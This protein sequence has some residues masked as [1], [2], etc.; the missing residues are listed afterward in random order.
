MP[1][2]NEIKSLHG[3]GGT[4]IRFFDGPLRKIKVHI[5]YFTGE[6][7]AISKVARLA[8]HNGVHPCRF[9][10]IEESHDDVRRHYYYPSFVITS[11]VKGHMFHTHD[12]PMRTTDVSRETI[13]SLLPFKQ[14]LQRI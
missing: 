12:L 4:V 13:Q 5:S 9:C 8:G 1:L 6:L 3:N 14:N 11:I 7:R 2:V 10:D